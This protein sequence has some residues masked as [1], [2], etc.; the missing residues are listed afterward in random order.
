M[1]MQN[2]INFEILKAANHEYTA[3]A[4]VN[5]GA[6]FFLHSS[7][8]PS[9][10]GQAWVQRLNLSSGTIFVVL[11]AGLGYHV[12]A[13][14]QALPEDSCIMLLY[15][16]G[17]LSLLKFISEKVKE[18]WMFD[19]RIHSLELVNLFDMA[20]V[21][22]DIMIAKA[23]KRI[24]ICPHFPCMRLAAEEYQQI[25]KE[26]VKKVED[27]MATNFNIQYTTNYLFFENYWKNFS[28][29]VKS[30]G[31]KKLEGTFA[32][33]PVIIIGA[34]PSLNRNIEE[35]KACK[36]HAIIIAAG[37][38]LGALS[39]H[40]IVPHFLVVTDANPQMYEAV[41]DFFLKDTI[42]VVGTSAEYRVVK[43]YPGAKLFVNTSSDLAGELTSY[44]PE[45][46]HI[47]Q[48]ISV[49]TGAV[50]FARA[51]GADTIILI[52]QD[53]AFGGPNEHHASG[54]HESAGSYA[55]W[56]RIKVPGYFGG[57]VETV[58]QFLS[59][60]EYYNQYVKEY[61]NIRFINATEGGALIAAM[62]NMSLKE[63]HKLI[64]KDKKKS[65]VEK[66]LQEMN[67]V[68]N[69]RM[70]DQLIAC[71]QTLLKYC[72]D[73]LE[74]I[75]A[76][77]E[78]MDLFLQSNTA[79]ELQDQIAGFSQFYQKLKEEKIYSYIQSVMDFRLSLLKF[80]TQDEMPIEIQAEYYRN[81]TSGLQM[82]V[83]NFSMWIEEN[84]RILEG[85][86]E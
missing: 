32:G 72:R 11:G 45:N 79:D 55:H 34:G 24:S 84:L 21:I 75:E 14:L 62:E 68:Q 78:E 16:P 70:D 51:C 60:I 73:F 8:S 53:L 10:E 19:K 61:N 58:G 26:L 80:Q 29:I 49:T 85:C 46:L 56:K 67:F 31:T 69:K 77:I 63:V 35:L 27:A 86:Y 64:L 18:K 59:V 30:Y 28:F 54:V 81:M 57:E 5:Q 66:I 9:E 23:I 41:S 65:Q 36:E 2:N 12:Q 22:G 48:T 47:Q 1:Y 74:E 82:L 50:D 15:T 13:L 4:S 38:A 52:G 44:L 25:E 20:I 3:K 33:I 39:K 37:T 6:A 40:H 17:E 83:S 7:V 42:L 43:E 71:L 76:F